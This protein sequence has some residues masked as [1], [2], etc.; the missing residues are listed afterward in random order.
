MNEH[1]LIINKIYP[2]N[3]IISLKT[4]EEQWKL[5][6][7]WNQKTYVNVGHHLTPEEVW[8]ENT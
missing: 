6:K 5:V 2:D 8:T 3:Q 4:E 1:N 7:F